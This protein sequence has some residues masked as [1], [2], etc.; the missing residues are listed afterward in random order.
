[1]YIENILKT[2]IKVVFY[3]EIFNRFQG[4]EMKLINIFRIY[5]KIL[6]TTSLCLLFRI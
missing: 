1:M 6:F 2:H 4:G 5:V 3:K